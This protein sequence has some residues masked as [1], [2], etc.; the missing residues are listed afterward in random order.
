[1]SA[2]SMIGS[3]T[4]VPNKIKH[5]GPD[6]L[7]IGAHYHPGVPDS[8][9]LERTQTFIDMYTAGGAKSCILAP[10]MLKARYAKI[11]WNGTFN[12][13]CAL[14]LMNVG[15]VQR[16]GAR[17]KLVIP[18][19]RELQ[20][21]AKADGHELEEELVQEMAYRSPE[22]SRWRPSMLLDRDYGRPME[23]EVILGDPIR[24][25]AELGVAVPIM[26]TVYELLKLATWKA[27][28]PS[29]SD[30]PSIA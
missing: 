4:E 29:E 24:R 30:E 14:M 15:E 26:T 16:S 2:V 21:V 9:S 25:A 6:R 20:A 28:N 7:Q 1:M 22:T 23:Y 12:T 10:D 3:F 13:I 19:M 11:L 27:G 8:V 18:I 17:E 5:I